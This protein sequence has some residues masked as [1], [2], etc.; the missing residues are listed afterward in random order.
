MQ[1]MPSFEPDK[2]QSATNETPREINRRILLNLVR[3]RQEVSRADLARLTGLQRSTV[4]LITEEL[5]EER[6]LMEGPPQRLPR[7][8]HPRHVS[9]NTQRSIIGIDLRPT[10]TTVALADLHGKLLWRETFPTASEPLTAIAEMTTRLQA[11]MQAHPDA[12]FDGIGVS[13]PG[14]ASLTTEHLVFT[15]NLRWPA[16]D[17]KSPLEQATGLSVQIENA[18]NICVLA[19]VWFGAWDRVRDLAIVTVSEGIGSGLYANGQL[20]RGG[21]GMAGE[22][23][24]VT[25]DPEGPLCPCGRQGCWE[26]YASQGAGLRYYRELAG[27]D[28]PDFARLLTLAGEGDA[29]AL[30]AFAKMADYLA[31]GMCMIVGGFAP[32]MIIVIGE[33]TRAWHLFEPVLQA[34]TARQS[35]SGPPPRILP[36]GDGNTTRLRG[37][38]ALVLQKHFGVSPL[39]FSSQV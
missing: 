31:R 10:V 23:G 2:I 36:G 30:A 26:V 1:A 37:T 17:L 13:L 8:R 20:V 35:L 3:L 18:A 9:L 16:F 38:V 12:V 33:V 34:Q 7:G 21:S 14:R 25:L 28:A 24:H 11:L 19:E 22:F 32:E 27:R 4:S 5:I 29:H 15:P 6:W 39:L